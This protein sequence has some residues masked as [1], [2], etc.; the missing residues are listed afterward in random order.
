MIELFIILCICEYLK[1]LL[2]L[3]LDIGQYQHLCWCGRGGAWWEW[4]FC[5]L[6]YSSVATVGYSRKQ[7]SHS[8]LAL[9]QYH[10][11][12]CWY[13]SI[14][15]WWCQL[16]EGTLG[17][18]VKTNYTSG[19]SYYLIKTTILTIFRIFIVNSFLYFNSFIR[20]PILP[21]L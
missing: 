15:S 10:Q 9:P 4:L 7:S 2:V 1:Q 20:T 11:W 6:L 3:E 8:G 18:E 17:N 13:Q 5:F 21:T 19:N 12:W 14:S 16:A